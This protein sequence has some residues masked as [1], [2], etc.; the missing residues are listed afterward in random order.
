MEGCRIWKLDAR[1]I[2]QNNGFEYSLP[3][4][5]KFSV[6]ANSAAESEHTFFTA[7]APHNAKLRPVFRKSG[8][9]N[10]ANPSD[11][12]NTSTKS[13]ISRHR[14]NSLKL[15]LLFNRQSFRLNT[16]N[17]ADFR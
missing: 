5:N 4:F 2:N 6:L 3:A 13:R 11:L 10:G 15:L 16:R 12:N 7:A 1:H 8:S 17:F 14:N 9:A